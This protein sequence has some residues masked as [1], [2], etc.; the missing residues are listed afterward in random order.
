MPA[1]PHAKDMADI[2][3]LLARL[4]AISADKTSGRLPPEQ[5]SRKAADAVRET[6]RGGS[7][8]LQRKPLDHLERICE[9]GWICEAAAKIPELYPYL[10]HPDMWI[11][12]GGR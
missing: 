1:R 8:T 4:K 2:G 6:R 10:K 7:P 3:D 12:R 11:R 5:A 9:N